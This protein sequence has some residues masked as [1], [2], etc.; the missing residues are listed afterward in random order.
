MGM[1]SYNTLDTDKELGYKI[2]IFI[3]LYS[4]C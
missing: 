4:D 3:R 1:L 2:E